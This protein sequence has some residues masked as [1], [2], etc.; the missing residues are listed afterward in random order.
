MPTLAELKQQYRQKSLGE[1]EPPE[2]AT[3]QTGDEIAVLRQKREHLNVRLDKG[4]E[5]LNDLA[6]RIGQESPE[7][8]HYF[9][10]W[11]LIKDEYEAVCDQITVLEARRQLAERKTQP[12]RNGHRPGERKEPDTS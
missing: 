9:A 11:L 5:F 4:C 2:G 6:E 10:Q 1:A 12:A 3:A 8:E 7:F